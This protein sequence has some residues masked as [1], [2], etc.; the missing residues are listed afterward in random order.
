MT[1]Q[2]QKWTPIVSR[3]RTLLCIC[4][5]S[6]AS[7]TSIK[8]YIGTACR[9]LTINNDELADVYLNTADCAALGK[10]VLNRITENANF[11]REHA[12]DCLAE[13]GRFVNISKE[14]ASLTG[15]ET[16]FDLAI[17]FKRYYQSYVSFAKFMI[18]VVAIERA[19]TT[20]ITGAL[21]TRVTA[22]EVQKSLSALMTPPALSEFQ[23]EQVTLLRISLLADEER[24]WALEEHYTSFK[25]LSC[26][27]ID[28]APYTR[29]YFRERLQGLLA[30][31]KEAR[32]KQFAELSLEVE[33]DG[34]VYREMLKRLAFDAYTL[35]AIELLRQY[36]YLRTFRVE[37]NTKSNFYIQPLFNTIAQKLFLS[38]RQTAALTPA[39]TIL[40]LE[41]G[42]LPSATELEKRNKDY[43]YRY[44]ESGITLVT[45]KEQTAL[46]SEEELGHE[47][48]NE[49][50]EVAG[51]AAFAG[52]IAGVA[53]VVITKQDIL[54]FKH[55]EVLVTTMTT[56][57]F[58]PAMKKA[59][60]I[61][62]NEGGV[63]CHA[64]IVARELKVPCI[65][66]TRV[67]TKIFKTGDVVKVDG[68][69]G[70]ATKLF[71]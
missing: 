7:M 28:E 42:V 30:E 33:T 37:M 50:A 3:R 43:G 70:V 31:P 39:E 35:G 20:T 51:T 36:V 61:V 1:T 5:V 19:L 17:L 41:K 63:L 13:C 52:E 45:G 25:W 40:A 49:S 68:E 56:P 8:D 18:I 11:P 53:R 38:A 71:C 69:K 46:L 22:K 12:A 24:D 32:E 6:E 2:N 29:A 58:V 16:N 26:Y 57:E 65:I 60:A 64:A 27:N 48:K 23:K 21:G 4:A 62:T 44:D 55:G 59:A 66:G 47:E 15:K 10:E 9:F 54:D 14:L 67:A 34:S